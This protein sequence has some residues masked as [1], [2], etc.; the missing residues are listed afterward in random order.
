MAALAAVLILA[1]CSTYLGSSRPS[2]PAKL[3]EPGWI[4]V[5]N[6]PYIAQR[7]DKDC[8]VAALAM[9]LAHWKKVQGIDEV[10][11]ACPPDPERGIE[12][13]MLRAFA[14]KKGLQTYVFDG[15]FKVFEDEL[16]R[17]RPVLVGMGKPTLGGPVSHFEVVVGYNPERGLVMTLD[18]A[19]GVRVND[20][21]GFREEWRLAEY[22]TLVIFRL[23]DK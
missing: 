21:A 16:S 17:G 20:E 5:T 12:V 8:G 23:N 2:D 22:L 10:R 6:V 14:K 15:E 3:L 18:P 4:A 7:E 11:E 1:G 9:V 19:L 13:S